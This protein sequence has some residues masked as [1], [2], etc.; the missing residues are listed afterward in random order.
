MRVALL[1]DIHGN[2]P[3]LQAVLKAAASLGASQLLVAG[4]L[5]GYYNE[6]LDVFEMLG[7]WR[8][9][10]VRGNHEELLTAAAA[11]SSLIA[12]IR[13]RY[14]S[15]IETA[16]A[17]LAPES[18]AWLMGLPHPLALELCGRRILLC[19]GSP[20]RV[21]EYIYPDAPDEVWDRLATVD[22]DVVVIGH[23]HYPL[24]RT[25]S[26]VVVVNPGSVGQPRNRVPGAHWALLDLGT[27]T[28]EQR[29]ENY[30]IS[31]FADRVRGDDPMNRYLADVLE[32]T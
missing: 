1:S 25:C 6:V 28:I 17:K 30:D 21:D 3:A 18:L 20:W 15:G 7:R 13:S 19:H 31:A 29:V 8:V 32:R 26:R 14:G 5:V 10:A 22:A 4:D 16:L 12:G 11:D 23:T 9:S 24:S 2:G 27:L